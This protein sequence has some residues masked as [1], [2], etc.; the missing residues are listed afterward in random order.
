MQRSPEL[1]RI[2]NQT[3]KRPIDVS[4]DDSTAPNQQKK[5]TRNSP[6]LCNVC[7]TPC[8]EGSIICH[9]CENEMHLACVG[10]SQSFHDYFIMKLRKPYECPNC[11]TKSMETMREKS[12]AFETQLEL[13]K[14][15]VAHHQNKTDTQL[16]SMSSQMTML[17]QTVSETTEIYDYKMESMSNRIDAQD[18]KI[19]KELCYIQGQQKQ[20]ELI[21]SGVPQNTNEDLKGVI[22]Q[23]GV[24]M[25]TQ[26]NPHHIKKVHRMVSQSNKNTQNHPPIL[27]K[28]TTTEK[29]NEVNDRYIELIKVKRPL[30]QSNIGFPGTDRIYMN[31][32]LPQCLAEIYKAAAQLKKDGRIQ[33]FHSKTTSVAVKIDDKWHKVQTMKEMA[34]IVA[35]R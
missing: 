32:H 18:E 4:D 10:M 31:A 26:I 14:A 20:D 8:M 21:I 1:V 19:S 23:I 24:F 28:F 27:V 17:V 30:T 16:I 2:P 29:R 13:L 5:R 12:T 35:P 34:S 22:T 9:E 33:S 11:T 15:N 6:P 7:K 3:E 25:R